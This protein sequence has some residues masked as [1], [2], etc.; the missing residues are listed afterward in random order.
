MRFYPRFLLDDNAEGGAGGGSAAATPTNFITEEEAKS[1]GFDSKEALTTF[2]K[3]KTAAPVTDDEKSKKDNIDKARFISYSAEN[4]LMKVEEYNQYE[5][6][7]SKADA[8]LVFE[9]YA[10][11]AKEDDPAAT[12]ADIRENFEREYRFK[13]EN[14]KSKARGVERLKKEAEEI[15]KPFHSKYEE[16]KNRFAEF[17]DLEAKYPTFK[18]FV[19]GVI[20]EL[21]PDKLTVAKFKDKIKDDSNEEEIPIEIELSEKDR[22]DIIKS[23]LNP[24]TF[25]DY[26]DSNGKTDDLKAAISKKVDG[27]IR[28]RKRE[29][30]DKKTWEAATGFGVRKGSNVGA[31]NPFALNSTTKRSV[32][33]KAE[34]NKV[35]SD[36]DIELRKKVNASR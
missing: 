23:F 6:L 33:G 11:E 1:F 2:L 10:A 21:T 27:V 17:K 32:E 3:E 30:I 34:A 12:D 29:E 4:D 9:K 19:S 22:E 7:K 15:R 16:A 26:R 25:R 14:E 31:E 35:V 13:S 18:E 28:A 8:D 20:K 5:A 36:N 24:K